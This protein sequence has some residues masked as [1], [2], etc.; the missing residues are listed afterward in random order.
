MKAEGVVTRKSENAV[1]EIVKE[2][3]EKMGR[4]GEEKVKRMGEI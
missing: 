3:K 2:R 4:E 1:R